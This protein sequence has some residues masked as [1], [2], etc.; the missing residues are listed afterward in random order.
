M[1]TERTDDGYFLLKLNG[2]IERRETWMLTMADYLSSNISRFLPTLFEEHSILF[3]GCSLEDSSI[4]LQLLRSIRGHRRWQHYALLPVNSDSEAT[5]KGQML[6]QL[7][8]DVIP[9]VP[10]SR[11]SLVHEV[12]EWIRPHLDVIAPRIRHRLEGSQSDLARTL[13]EVIEWHKAR[14]TLTPPERAV[15]AATTVSWIER[16]M[17]PGQQGAYTVTRELLADLAML[18]VELN[19]SSSDA[20]SLAITTATAA[21]RNCEALQALLHRLEEG[22]L[23]RR[24]TPPQGDPVVRELYTAY[25]DGHWMKLRRILYRCG[26]RRAEYGMDRI[27]IMQLRAGLLAGGDEAAQSWKNFGMLVSPQLW[28]YGRALVQLHNWEFGN[29]ID[30]LSYLDENQGFVLWARAVA[31]MCRSVPAFSIELNISDRNTLLLN[32]KADLDRARRFYAKFPPGVRRLFWT[33][34]RS[35]PG[36]LA[37]E[38]RQI[39]SDEMHTLLA[40]WSFLCAKRLP[41]ADAEDPKYVLEA[42][43]RASQGDLM[44]EWCRQVIRLGSAELPAASVIEREFKALLMTTQ[45]RCRGLLREIAQLYA[46][47]ADSSSIAERHLQEIIVAAP[48]PVPENLT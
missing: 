27:N 20:V 29:A 46:Q 2:T 8:V 48:P 18:A 34:K 31:S 38:P 37:Y 16:A 10:D 1:T 5:A 35:K 36:E 45:R 14:D 47:I 24:T 26:E 3:L 11:H 23:P 6:E 43:D 19:E 17:E 21:G 9:Y 22:R 4:E 15:L 30:S 41:T 7:G 39:G 33:A 28:P 32:A 44:L 12:I 25:R 42:L 40:V 13:A